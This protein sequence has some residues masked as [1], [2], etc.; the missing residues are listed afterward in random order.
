MN[1]DHR[2]Y[3]SSYQFSFVIPHDYFNGYIFPVTCVS[4]FWIGD[5]NCE[6]IFFPEQ[7]STMINYYLRKICKLCFNAATLNSRSRSIIFFNVWF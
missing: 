2:H 4:S 3:V 7:V 6:K 5:L 1:K